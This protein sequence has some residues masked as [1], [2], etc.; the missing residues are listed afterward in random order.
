M[1][2]G[3]GSS[4]LVDT[5]NSDDLTKLSR[6]PRWQTSNDW[7]TYSALYPPQFGETIAFAAELYATVDKPRWGK[8]VTEFVQELLKS[9]FPTVAEAIQEAQDFKMGSKR[10][11]G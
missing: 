4:S 9:G 1:G 8:E 5:N 2:L 6:Y 10:T 3:F 11:I 7:T